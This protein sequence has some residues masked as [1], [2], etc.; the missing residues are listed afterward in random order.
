MVVQSDSAMVWTDVPDPAPRADEVVMRVAAS[1]VNRAD[2]LQRRGKYPPP[3]GAP[4]WMGLEAAGTIEA[5]GPAVS[6]DD[7]KIGDS[8]C[9]L[10][11]GGGYAERVALPAAQLLPVPTGM[12]PTLAASV[13]E[14]FATAYL[15]LYLEAGLSEG[16]TVLVHA[17]A[18][19][20]GTAAIQIARAFGSRVISTVGSARK[21]QFVR[22]L[23][24]SEV[25]DRSVVDIDS[26]LARLA[27]TDPGI[28][29]VLDCLGGDAMARLLPLLNI[30]GRWVIISLLEG[31]RIDLD[32][33]PLLSRRLRVIGSTLRA[34]PSAEKARILGQLRSRVWPLLES[35]EIAPVVH[36]VF[37]IEEVEEAHAVL[38]RRENIG[39]VVLR[40]GPSRS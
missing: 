12:D 26:E 18:S 17:G 16:E 22:E 6:G 33:R 34:R 31:S 29:V 24:A 40:I 14:V 25:I 13:P 32:L 8:V 1:A 2:L 5:I 11:A 3:P 19:G 20:V 35:G 7:W 27:R 9:A 36:A 39:K 15:N 10:L 30:D 4:E 37:P 28:D 23:G 38:E 21:A